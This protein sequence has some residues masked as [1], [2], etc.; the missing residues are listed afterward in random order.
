[1]AAPSRSSSHPKSGCIL[2]T[3]FRNSR[4]FRANRHPIL[5][6]S[7]DAA[8]ITAVGI[9][10]R[11]HEEF[12]R[13]LAGSQ[14]RPEFKGFRVQACTLNICF[15]GVNGYPPRVRCVWRRVTR[16]TGRKVRCPIVRINSGQ[17]ASRE[18][19]SS[20]ATDFRR[21]RG[22]STPRICRRRGLCQCRRAPIRD[23]SPALR[24]R[25][26]ESGDD[27]GAG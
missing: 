21:P 12:S 2:N 8:L 23:A 3:R 25:A 17:A 1:M 13:P 6:D 20:R 5:N 9:H 11:T 22:A 24:L 10:S 19:R 18:S 27:S 15:W 16:T 14:D 4:H 7:C 26:S